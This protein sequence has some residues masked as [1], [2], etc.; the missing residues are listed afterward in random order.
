MVGLIL[1]RCETLESYSR[2]VKK[3]RKNLLKYIAVSVGLKEDV[4]E[5]MFGEVVNG[6]NTWVPVQP[7][8]NALVVNI[9][10]TIQV[11]TN[12]KYKSVEHR[13]VTH[14]EKDRLS[15]ATFYSPGYEIELGP[16]PELVDE[17]NPCKYKRN[18]HG[19]YSKHYITNK[20]RGKKNLDFAKIRQN[21]V[22]F[23]ARLFEIPDYAFFSF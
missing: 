12:G 19:E 21:F 20:L 1:A 5:E 6:D 13:A 14:K 2:E 17:N 7:I 3:L 16:M 9:G 15:I 22:P 8:P 23:C 11:L 4:F 18:I 10:D